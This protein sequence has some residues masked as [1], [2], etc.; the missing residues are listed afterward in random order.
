MAIH[1]TAPQAIYIEDS[2]GDQ[3]AVDANGSLA[4]VATGPDG[5]S[6]QVT[7]Q[8]ALLTTSPKSGL[9]AFGEQLSAEPTPV[10]QVKFPY[11]TIQ[12]QE[13]KQLA[14]NGTITSA[15][16][17]LV[18]STGAAANQSARAL[19]VEH[20]AYE[21]GNGI[22]ARFTALFTTGVANSIQAAGIGDA[23]EGFFFGYDG[24]TFGIMSRIGGNAEVR[25]LTVTTKS[26][27][28]ENIT[29]T[30]D[31]DALA[32]V[33]VTNGADTTITAKEIAA[34]D[35]SDL[36]TGWTATAVGSTVVFISFDA[37]SHAG[38]FTLSGASTAVGTFAQTLAGVAPTETWVPQASWNGHDTFDG[39]GPT[40]VTLD[41]TKGNVYQ[42]KFQYLGFGAQTFFIEDP[43]DGEFHLVHTIQYA[44]A[45]TA[46]SLDNPSMPLS[47]G[48]ANAANTSDLVV[49]TG[50]MAAF[51]EGETTLTGPRHGV[52]GVLTTV[53]STETPILTVRSK[54][55]F[56]GAINRTRSKV[57][58][59]GFSA[60]HT[61][62]IVINVYAN[63]Q[64]EAASFTDVVGVYSPL[65]YD[66]AGTAHT[67][68]Q[69]LFS[70]ELGKTG[71]EII[72]FSAAQ[73]EGVLQPGHSLTF[74]AEA[75]AGSSGEANVSLYMV[76]LF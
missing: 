45:N 14:N 52:K 55:V 68:G 4:A 7:N 72:D 18:C 34:A 73:Q 69:Y 2:D 5:T 56:S 59:A 9:S 26:S 49:K 46:P 54:E 29:I 30:L 36:G 35:Y 67:G 44:N 43:T 50:S 57:L 31:G 65:E 33:A 24:A 15:D 16:S 75:S 3:V 47:I 42:I 66:T 61:K 32:T 27:T 70:I 23:G 20:A 51:V 71:N 21:A 10:V 13:I 48:C 40:G 41:P 17:M 8:Q 19:T 22:C 64:I 62:P 11:T 6:T 60:E 76:D 63:A 38:S 53:S 12:P 74:T 25:T 58:T 1:E 37:A 28:A 39:T